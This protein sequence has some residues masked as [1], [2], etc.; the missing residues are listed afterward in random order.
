MC[1]R[2]K[3]VAI[4]WI[5]CHNC[6]TVNNRTDAP[7]GNAAENIPPRTINLHQVSIAE[8]N[9]TISESYSEAAT[10]E[11]DDRVKHTII[12]ALLNKS[13]LDKVCNREARISS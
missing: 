6:K 2:G 9:L 12:P 4:T 7:A 8:M 5:K 10:F 13:A 11:L 3:E 1:N